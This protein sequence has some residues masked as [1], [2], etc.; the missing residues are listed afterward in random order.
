MSGSNMH[1]DGQPLERL[2]GRRAPRHAAVRV[3]CVSTLALLASLITVSCTAPEPTRRPAGPQPAQPAA[4]P[5]EADPK[6]PAGEI[7]AETLD[8][9]RMDQE[10][11]QP[12]VALSVEK[13]PLTIAG[14]VYAH[15]IGSHANSE[16]TLDLK[17]VA[18]QFRALV[19]VDDEVG[20]F[21]SVVFV[22]CV[23]GQ[24][25]ARTPVL[26]G[27]DAAVPISV[28]LTGA[29]EMTL[30]VE[31]AGD[32]IDYDHA[33]WAEARL[34]L[35]RNAKQKPEPV[36]APPDT[37]PQIA[38]GMPAE[39]AIHAPRITGATPG[40]PFLFRIPATGDGALH[41]SARNLPPGL[42]L[43]PDTGI[44]TGALRADGAT[45][46]ELTVGGA[47]GRATA[48]LTIVGG[49]RVLALTPPMGWN[50]WNVWGTAVDDAK[51]RAA[52]DWMVKSG[53]AAHGFQYI[54]I[55]DAWEGQ[56]DADGR[57]QSNDKFPDMKALADYVHSKGLKLG[58][59]SSPGPKTCAGYEGSYQHEQQDAETYA[60]WGLDL[61]KYDWCSYDGIAKDKS[62]PELRKPYEVM[63]AA[64]DACGRDI[65]YSLCQYGMGDVWA[66]GESVGGNYWRTTG[67]IVDHWGSM[68]GIGFG[69]DGHELYSG[70][71]H[72]NDPDML[73]VGQ[74]GWGPSLHPTNLTPNEQVTHITLWSLLAAPLLIGC[75]LEQLDDF[76]RAL[77]TNPEVLG[78][79][80]DPLGQQARRVA[81][82]GRLEVWSRPLADGTIAV[83]LFNRTGRPATITANWSD[84]SL[85]GRQ[86]ARN[87]WLR[88]DEGTF[89]GKYSALVPRHGVVLLKIGTPRG[90]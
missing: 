22:V 28:D 33:D 60:E 17:G 35:V 61:L 2:I 8:L 86:P 9:K 62:L 49:P 53:L 79:D 20:K 4:R 13:H 42:R 56:R 34:V 47:T 58:I 18:R 43:D 16:W 30:T 64:L 31:D 14:T 7:W 87:L 27:G 37:P 77:L 73:V 69:Q 5:K 55:D 63:R 72:W 57:I 6:L 83:G 48:T 78:V 50:S 84:L 54:N 89:D 51:V 59:Y 36:A 1:I 85:S 11:G 29:R 45:T 68:A 74:V 32:G 19:G 38:M 41:F 40:R 81:T 88:R 71:G 21:G 52:A 65:V 3:L 67:D 12:R 15:G 75:D 23:D 76:T 44:I 66:W 70:P 90:G 82:A 80:Q 10:W 26:H 39:P 46:V 25:A 24:E